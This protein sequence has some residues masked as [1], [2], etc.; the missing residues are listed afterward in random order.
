MGR[1]VYINGA[2]KAEEDAFISI[3]DRG[4]L[5]A[6]GIYEV[7]AVID[8]RLVDN[9]LHL[10]RLER[11]LHEIA[12]PMPMA[13]EQILEIQVDLIRRNQLREGVVYLQVTRGSADRDFGYA[14]G[15]RP[16]FIAFT[17][18]KSLVDAPSVRNGVAVDVTD[19]PRWSRRDIKTIMLLG[20]VLAKKKAN[21]GGFHEVWF[22]EDGYITEGASSTAFILTK[23]NVV[24]TRPNSQAVLPGCTRR[25]LQKLAKEGGVIIEERR[26]TLQEAYEAKEA[27][28]T[29]ASS[30]V[31]PIIRVAQ[32]VI[33]DGTPGPVTRR[34]QAAYLDLARTRSE[35]VL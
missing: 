26:F 11:S 15:M 19:D 35:P 33:G 13:I 20:Q 18:A 32:R 16:N 3:F 7:T 1:T 9:D 10:A 5:F 30:L 12:I 25:A 23:D 8:G 17:Q 21:A 28:L 24:L 27:F 14:E 31:T 6:D 22:V 29:S 2:F 34:L 4:F